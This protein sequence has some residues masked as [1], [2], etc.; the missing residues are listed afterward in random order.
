M[1]LPKSYIQFGDRYPDLLRDFEN[2]GV[3]CLE[4]GP[5]DL[6]ARRL[7]K[8]GMAIATSSRGG[9]KSQT[10]KALEDGFSQDEIRHA[11]VLALPTIGFPSMIAAFEW[12]EETFTE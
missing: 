10:R 1:S 5:L 8:L 9:I 3:K 12:I 11:A 6:K 7:V 2:I 4:A